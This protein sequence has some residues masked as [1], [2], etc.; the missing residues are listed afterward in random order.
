MFK[1]A[2]DIQVGAQLAM[3]PRMQ[4]AIRLLQL[5]RIEL[6][7]EL[8]SQLEQNPLLEEV[9][10]VP[11][12]TEESGVESFSR[13]LSEYRYTS[14][15]S[16]Q[17][18]ENDISELLEKQPARPE[19][20]REHL[21]E[22]LELCRMCDMDRMIGTAIIESLDEDGYLREPLENIHN[23]LGLPPDIDL[24]DT[25]ALLHLIQQ[26]DPVGVGARNLGEC[27][28]LQLRQLPG[29][30]PQRQIAIRLVE[31]YLELLAAGR[32]TVL[33]KKLGLDETE[34]QKALQLI[35]TLDP[36]PGTQLGGASAGYIT[37]D[38]IVT[39]TGGGWKVTLNSDGLPKLGVNNYYAAAGRTC[40]KRDAAYVRNQLQEARWFIKSLEK[41]HQT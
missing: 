25:S 30:T 32:M 24:K 22:Q 1:T 6:R 27:L 38:V 4:Q 31:Q 16:L 18:S 14:T 5:S 21:L 35:Q 19:T 33:R 15:S 17:G 2:I 11:I 37:P 12:D 8:T 41:R 40:S 7:Q 13:Q 26:F 3:T 39:Q 34:L 10:E 20:L 36:K 28:G 29:N 23:Q 9:E